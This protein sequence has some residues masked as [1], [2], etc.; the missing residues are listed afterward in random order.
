MEGLKPCPYCGRSNIYIDGYDHAAGKRWRVM[1][2][3]CMATV[4]DG[5]VQQKYRAIEKWNRRV[6]DIV[7]CGECKYWDKTKRFLSACACAQWS[8]SA[9]KK[10]LRWLQ[11]NEFCS[12]GERREGEG[13]NA[14]V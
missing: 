4:D 9:D 8:P 6:P 11:P 14:E 7:R 10:S 5:T 3:D 1:C 13:K 2:L 12:R